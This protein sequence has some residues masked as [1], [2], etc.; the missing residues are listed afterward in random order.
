MR[1]FI[2]LLGLGLAVSTVKAAD[3]SFQVTNRGAT[4][5]TGILATPKSGDPGAPIPIGN[6]SIGPGETSDVSFEAP[7]GLCVFDLS[8]SAIDRE[9]I[10]RPD[11]DLCQV[12][13]LIIE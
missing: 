8:I 3:L 5:V 7:G 10:L 9:D 2:V 13:V 11:V 1:H 4:T 12:E 6:A